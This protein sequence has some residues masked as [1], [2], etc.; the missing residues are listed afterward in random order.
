[1][2]KPMR[3]LI[4]GAGNMANFHAQNYQANG[5]E[6][7]GAVDVKEDNLAQFCERHKVGKSFG[8]VDDALQWGEFDSAS[9][10]TP[11]PMHKDASIAL[12]GA[13][14]HVLCEKPLAPNHADARAMADAAKA[15][16]TVAMV[17]MTYR[18]SAALNAAH[19]LVRDGKIGTLR[20]VQ[21]EYR[22]SWLAQDSWGD[23]RSM[24][25]WLWRLSSKHGS[26]G[27][28]GD[29]GV[30]LLDFACFA[31][32]ARIADVRCL[33]RAF[34]KADNDR[35]GE[36]DLDANDS[37]V[38]TASLDNGA[39]AVLQASRWM[40]GYI[41]DLHLQ[42]FGDEGALE[43]T[44]SHDEDV[45]RTCLGTADLKAGKWATA[46]AEPQPKTIERFIAAVRDGG[47][48]DPDFERGCEL[49]QAIDLAF[50][51]DR[52]GG[53]HATAG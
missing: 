17:H 47:P 27:V 31:A 46:Q 53:V 37:A 51:A 20:H 29:V 23:W 41:N 2:S 22:Q 48:R 34:H 50:A 30:H 18:Q 21:A 1:M 5:V 3:V 11:D 15:A 52:D 35:I 9:V 42:L 28:L 14:K 24:D 44:H 25:T 19:A 45:L 13:G 7:V 43:V 6:V 4:V 36:Y 16:G 12:L 49:Q 38:I 39:I 40:T 10:V 26:L 8:S 32:D 33:L